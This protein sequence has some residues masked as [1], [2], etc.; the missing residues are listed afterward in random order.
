[1]CATAWKFLLQ[2]LE[3]PETKLQHIVLKPEL[4][5]RESSQR[6]VAG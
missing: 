2:R 5:I 3:N 4:V 1:M 6:T